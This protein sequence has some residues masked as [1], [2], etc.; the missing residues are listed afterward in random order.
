MISPGLKGSHERIDAP[1]LSLR[2]KHA[3]HSRNG[4]TAIL[5]TPFLMSSGKMAVVQSNPLRSHKDADNKLDS[6]LDSNPLKNAGEVG[7]HG[8]ETKLHRLGDLL[9]AATAKQQLYKSRLLR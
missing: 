7:S 2:E 1:A 3:V 9:V 5:M 6:I 8:G 4:Q